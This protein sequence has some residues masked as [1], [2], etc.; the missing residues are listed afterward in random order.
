MQQWEKPYLGEQVEMFIMKVAGN[1]SNNIFLTS[2][3]TVS[4]GEFKTSHM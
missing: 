4:E 3:F 1:M 2:V